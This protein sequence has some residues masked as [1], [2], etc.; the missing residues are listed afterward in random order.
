[1]SLAEG[2]VL[3]FEKQLAS[4]YERKVD[5]IKVVEGVVP[6]GV[7]LVHADPEL[8]K[9]IVT[10]HTSVLGL[11]E[12][13]KDRVRVFT[14][15]LSK[16]E[17]EV[18]DHISQIENQG[19]IIQDKEA[20]CTIKMKVVG[21]AG[22]GAAAVEPPRAPTRKKDV[23][24]HLESSTRRAL[25]DL[26]VNPDRP[27]DPRIATQIMSHIQFTPLVKHYYTTTAPTA[28]PIPTRST[29]RTTA[30]TKS[31]LKTVVKFSASSK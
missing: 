21:G 1:M 2:L 17:P 30:S 14:E 16:L 4:Q 31:K 10:Q 23:M 5:A 6:A 3:I 22:G 12:R 15:Q 7:A 24:D 25:V 29:S 9:R 8:T 20:T 18:L 26:G 19:C 28:T 27:Y 13:I 11:R